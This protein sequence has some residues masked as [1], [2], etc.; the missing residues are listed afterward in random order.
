MSA[1][2]LR[3][4]APEPSGAIEASTALRVLCALAPGGLPAQSCELCRPDAGFWADTGSGTFKR[5]HPHHDYRITMLAGLEVPVPEF[6]FVLLDHTEPGLRAALF[7]DKAVASLLK[8]FLG[9]EGVWD[10]AG[11]V[12]ENAACKPACI[13][14]ILLIDS[15]LFTGQ[16]GFEPAGAGG[17]ASS[18]RS[19]DGIKVVIYLAA[20]PSS[21]LACEHTRMHRDL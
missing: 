7:A 9:N 16:R 2:R 11:R 14:K 20:C 15:C 13:L 4:L 12:L 6:G 17:F 8:G 5:V 21:V 19:D 1:P 18:L 3:A 10:L